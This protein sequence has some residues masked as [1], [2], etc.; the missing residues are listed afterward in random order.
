MTSLIDSVSVRIEVDDIDAAL[1]TYQALA[2]TDRIGRYEFPEFTLA[3]VGPFML[4]RGEREVLERFRR[5]ATLHVPD[6]D[7]T[8]D[9][10][11]GH[12]GAVIDGPVAAAGGARTIVR[13]R[14]GNVFECFAHPA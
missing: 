3:V 14:D 4:L 6:L 2:G 1:P 13:D 11:T 9:A 8:V 5:A 7:A 12:G 10:F